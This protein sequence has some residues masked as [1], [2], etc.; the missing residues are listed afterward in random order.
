MPR[1][2]RIEYAGAV[3]HVMNR[4]DKGEK[5]FKDQQDYEI[6]FAGMG[7][8]C[9]RCGWKVHAFVY[10]PNH[11]HWLLETPEPNLVSGMK[12]F[13]GAYSQRFN[14][15]HGERGHVF[16]GRYKAL[17]I[18]PDSGGYF[19]TVSTY[20]H[21]NPARA[22]LVIKDVEGLNSYKW[23]SYPAYLDTR[24]NRPD[25][26]VVDR[27]L[28]NI[29]CKDTAAG[30]RE[31][32]KF[33]GDVLGELRRKKGREAYKQEW[34]PIR[35]GWFLG[36]DEFREKLIDCMS[37]VVE[38]KQ[39]ESYSGQGIV[40]HDEHQAKKLLARG[41]KALGMRTGD[42]K[43]LCKGDELKCVLAW[44][45]HTRTMVSHKWISQNLEM[46]VISNMTKYIDSVK[47]PSTQ[48]LAILKK[49]VQKCRNT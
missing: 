15:R 11:F 25:W 40:R 34:K 6:F 12:W 8:V 32:N 7:E 42:L 3:Y 43:G 44:L 2:P 24:R 45:I 38:D 31:Y 49:K 28:G 35:Y 30:R 33:M 46:G 39:R 23:S 9:D 5:I 20:I 14:S 37:K 22:G 18:Q 26:L 17:P 41:L 29:A 48:R 21:L 36:G 16:Q 19:E 4:G 1:K 47:H 13:L 10:M 27:V